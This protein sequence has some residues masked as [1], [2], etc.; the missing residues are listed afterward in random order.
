M[1]DDGAIVIH[2]FGPPPA[3]EGAPEVVERT[4]FCYPH[5]PVLD[6]NARTVTCKRCKLR[7]D[8]FDVL[9]LVARDHDEWVRLKKESSAMRQE[10]DAMKK[11]ERRVK[12]R[13]KSHRNK[14]AVEAVKA[15][16]LKDYKR[17][18]EIRSRTDDVRR[19][20]KRIDQL[21]AMSALVDGRAAMELLQM[22]KD[23][24]GKKGSS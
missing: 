19:A 9:L 22:P 15:E 12:A 6:K 5:A 17:R 11:E 3:I 10:L 7:L 13:T 20:L 8:P 14:D 21:T 4:G 23:E 1:S 2:L 16:R 18:L 24:V